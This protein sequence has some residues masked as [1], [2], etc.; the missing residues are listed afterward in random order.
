MATT[1]LAVWQSA[2]LKSRNILGTA[3]QAAYLT[4]PYFWSGKQ[5]LAETVLISQPPACGT[6]CGAQS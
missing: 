6:F 3:A 4:P 1:S 5:I 2:Q